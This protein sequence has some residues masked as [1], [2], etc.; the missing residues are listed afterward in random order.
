MAFV[1]LDKLGVL[2]QRVVDEQRHSL[3][4]RASGPPL[5]ATPDSV[6]AGMGQELDGRC[7]TS[8]PAGQ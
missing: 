1:D 7:S 5:P 2:H 4:R 8:G 3:A 6:A